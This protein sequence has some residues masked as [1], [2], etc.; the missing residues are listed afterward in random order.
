MEI[1]SML[2]FCELS[3]SL[4][5]RIIWKTTQECTYRENWVSLDPG[6]FLKPK[7]FKYIESNMSLFSTK[8]FMIYVSSASPWS[9][10]R[11]YFM[12]VYKNGL[13]LE[14]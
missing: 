7:Q 11:F 8:G 13:I 5:W 6:F 4:F 2:I 9:L 12:V 10:D 3:S 14:L 1:D